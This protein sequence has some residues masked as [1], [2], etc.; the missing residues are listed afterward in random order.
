M[1][2]TTVFETLVDVSSVVQI[3][4]ARVLAESSYAAPNLDTLRMLF[5][6]QDR[7]NDLTR[8]CDED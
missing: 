7:L 5:V 3:L 2:K 8:F 4:K 6:W 1:S